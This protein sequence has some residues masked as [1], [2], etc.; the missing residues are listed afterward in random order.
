MPIRREGRLQTD[1]AALRSQSS[2][3]AYGQML[4]K[5]LFQAA[6]QDAFMRA[7]ASS[8]DDLR[9]L[10]FVEDEGLK[11]W[12]W[13]RLYAPFDGSWQPLMLSQR[14]PLTLYLPSAADRRFPPI[15]RRDLRALIVAVSPAGLE[16]YGMD[17]FDVAAAV[18]GVR[19]ALGPIPHDLLADLPQAAGA[20]TLDALAVQLTA[21]PYTLLHLICHGHYVRDTGETA[22]Y[23]ADAHG[24]VLAVAASELIGRLQAL[25]SA[26]GLPHLAFLATCESAHPEAEGALGGLGQRLV[27]DLGMP[28]VVAMTDRVSVNTAGQL[29]AAFYPRLQQH[30]EP[31]RALVEACI[32]LA[33]RGDIT[34]PAL[35]SRLGGRPLFSDAP[36]RD[37]TAAEIQFGLKRLASL[38]PERAPA[39]QG[40]LA[41][42]EGALAATLVTSN[43]SLSDTARQER[44]AALQAVGA[45]CQEMVDISFH[46]LAVG[47]Q[48]P[49][50]D[51]RCPFPGLAA[52]RLD[53]RKFFFGREQL[54]AQLASRL[55][56][57]P[58]LALSGPSGSGKSSLLFAGLIPAW[59]QQEPGLS[60]AVMRPGSDP[61]AQLETALAASPGATTLLVVDQFEELFTLTDSAAH[62]QAFVDRLLAEMGQRRV[63]LTMRGDFVDDCAAYPALYSA[64]QAGLQLISPLSQPELRSAME[65]QAA[66]V[67]LRFEADLANTILDA[68]EGEPGAMPLLQHLL[69]RLWERRHGRWLRAAEYRQLGGVTEAL[70]GTAETIYAGFDQEDQQRMRNIFLRLVR[71]D[72][73]EDPRDTRRRLALGELATAGGEMAV[74]VRVVNRL[75][76]ERLLISSVNP[77]TGQDE[78]EFA[79][80]ALISEWPR[81]RMWINSDR[82]AHLVRQQLGQAAESWQRSKQDRSYLY[83]GSRLRTANA[84]AAIHPGSLNASE[85]EFLRASSAVERSA[86]QTR[87]A[88]WAAVSLLP[89]IVAVLLMRY[90]QVGPFREP[91]LLWSRASIPAQEGVTWVDRSADG[92]LLAAIH[93]QDKEPTLV[94][95]SQDGGQTWTTHPLQPDSDTVTQ[96]LWHDWESGVAYAS[97]QSGLIFRSRDEGLTWDRL[98]QAPPLTGE[99]FA[100]GISDDGVLLA[101]DTEGGILRQ[102][103]NEA[104]WEVLV[105]CPQTGV[106]QLTWE[107]SRLLIGALSEGLWQWSRAGGCQQ[108]ASQDYEVIMGFVTLEKTTYFVGN[109]GVVQLRGSDEPQVLDDNPATAIAVFAGGTPILIASS[110]SLI[111]WHEGDD[112]VRQL[113]ESNF[114]YVAQL[115]ADEHRADRLWVATSKG[116][117]YSDMQAWLNVQR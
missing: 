8:G 80:E 21:E 31:D 53:E 13:E 99:L 111:W 43:E 113:P 4:G 30:G 26:R 12:R 39:L 2:A 45:L 46:A 105:D 115:Y 57:H 3:A 81:L 114:S 92:V 17:P 104:G 64:L 52:F 117:F 44:A 61:A 72:D 55:A 76:D 100:I 95:R 97:T 70:A 102:T 110:G 65:Q 71:F 88:M 42:Q 10:L 20:P 116:L 19:S 112:K 73:S 74:T 15:G 38:L 90:F 94:A 7:L 37:L 75:A 49:A 56:A 9:V 18:A 96:V 6:V 78:V 93:R 109:P 48:P 60:V 108:L 58:F 91:P 14:A 34:A 51:G 28:A 35:Y 82:Q 25:R 107:D 5:A 24:Q 106:L 66:V 69:R 16:R 50:Y 29:A 32:G 68:V 27:R 63:V 54:V 41:R 98:P 87:G 11:Q 79:H 86:R 23:L 62:R 83:R 67:G 59:Q 89:I 33:E 47:D 22:L 84:W 77:T 36:G 1:E 101:A 85:G 103:G 40:E